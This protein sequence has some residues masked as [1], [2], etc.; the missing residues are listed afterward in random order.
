[1]PEPS[2]TPPDGPSRDPADL[3]KA[4]DL[5]P[6]HQ[7]LMTPAGGVVRMNRWLVELLRKLPHGR[8]LEEALGSYARSIARVP[9]P[10]GGECCCSVPSVIKHETDTGPCLLWGWCV[11]LDC[12]GLGRL[13]LM[14]VQ[15]L[16]SDLPCDEAIREHFGLTPRQIEVARLL[17]EGRS[18]AAIAAALGISPDTARHHTEDVMRKMGVRS[19]A[20]VGPKLRSIPRDAKN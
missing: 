20:E 5:I 3:F 9:H 8:Y 12:Y 15:P 1:M 18:N 2:S 6:Q 11:E 17:A 7:A 14:T 16:A 13:V 4:M 19:R 10:R